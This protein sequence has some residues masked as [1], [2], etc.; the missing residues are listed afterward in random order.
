MLIRIV[1]GSGFVLRHTLFP[2]KAP[3]S[4]VQVLFFGAKKL[5]LFSFHLFIQILN[6]CGSNKSQCYAREINHLTNCILAQLPW[7]EEEMEYTVYEEI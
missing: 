6:W 7:E 5:R 4:E 3:H 2:L 1:F